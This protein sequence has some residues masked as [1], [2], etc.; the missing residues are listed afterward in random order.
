MDNHCSA[1]SHSNKP[2]ELY[3]CVFVLKRACF[4]VCVCVCARCK[5]LVCYV[6]VCVAERVCVCFGVCALQ[7]ESECKC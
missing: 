5:E 4:S 2:W 3:V 1:L 7:K 6:L